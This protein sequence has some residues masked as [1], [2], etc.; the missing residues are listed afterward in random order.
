M[1]KREIRAKLRSNPDGL[2]VRQLLQDDTKKTSISNTHNALRAMPDT[3]IDR[4][5]AVSRSTYAAVWCAVD[6]PDDCPK[7][8]KT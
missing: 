6:V 8:K 1:R 7:P 3:Y 4:W 5:Q 2:T